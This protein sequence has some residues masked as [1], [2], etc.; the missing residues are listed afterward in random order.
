MSEYDDVMEAALRGASEAAHETEQEKQKSEKDLEI[1]PCKSWAVLVNSWRKALTWTD[2]LDRA[3]S[4]MLASVTSTKSVGDQLWVKVIGPPACGKSTLCEALSVNK[5]Y[6]KAVSTLRGFHSGYRSGDEKDKDN[7]LIPLIMDKS[8]VIK[9]GDTLLQ[10][11][12]RDQVLS[13]ARDLYDSVSRAH[14]RSGIDRSYEGVRFTIILCGTNSL[15]LLDIS[16]L[17]E[18]FLDCVIMEMID[19]ELEDEILMR[20]ANQADYHMAYESD[21]KVETQYP[22]ELIK[23]HQL[24]GGYVSYL[25]M[26]AQRL[27]TAIDMNENAKRRCMALAK[28]V[29]FMRARPSVKQQESEGREL[30]TRLTK[31]MVRL[32]KCLA[33]VLNRDQVD[34]EVMRRTALVAMDT[35]RGRTLEIVKALSTFGV[36]GAEPR[37]ISSVTRQLEDKERYLLRFLRSLGAIE[38]FTVRLPSGVHT[39]TKWRLTER[40]QQ[41][42]TEVSS[43]AEAAVQD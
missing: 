21:G 14:Y 1:K 7:S 18:R 25:R 42:Y 40:M 13:E 8:L 36:A 30:A 15:R 37:Q 5:K 39:R 32:A 9:D 34:D 10:L 31:Q 3:L 16:E 27:L 17:G 20:V 33:V 41:L 11:P 22:P 43:D 28:F 24:T 29:A 6:V 12:N 35:A 38:T 26:N 2:G 19:E 4:V 23:A